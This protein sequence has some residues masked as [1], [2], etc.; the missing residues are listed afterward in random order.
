M[1][2]NNDRFV[3]KMLAGLGIG[4]DCASKVQDGVFLLLHSPSEDRIHD[5]V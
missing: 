1:K 2:C 3:L 4:F 5:N